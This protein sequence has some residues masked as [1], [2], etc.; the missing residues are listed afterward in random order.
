M[1]YPG[2]K[3]GAGNVEPSLDERLIQEL[4]ARPGSPTYAVANG[5]GLR[6]QT[7]LV[8]KRLRQ[9]EAQGL[10]R[11]GVGPYFRFMISWWAR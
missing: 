1:G 3:A 9:L 6:G 7:A 8:R 11:S 5:V 2:S 4:R 10:V